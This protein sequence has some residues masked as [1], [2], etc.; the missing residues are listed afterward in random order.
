MTDNNVDIR[1]ELPLPIDITG[2]L[3]NVI[4]L[5]WP[6]AVIKDGK[7]DWR[8]DNRLVLSVPPEDRH[9]NAKKAKKYAEVK[10]HLK[11]ETDAQIAELGPD[12][13]DMGLPEYLAN[14]YIAMARTWMDTYPEATNYLESKLYDKERNHHWVFTVAKGSDRTP[15]SLRKKAEERTAELEAT[16]E[17]LREEIADLR[18][19]TT[20]CEDQEIE[21]NRLKELLA[22][23]DQELNYWSNR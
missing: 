3:I 15:H 5:T 20:K 23:K 2:T 9:K 16:V 13:I 18:P 12:S 14:L 19:L 21:I 10:A 22:E 4:G 7:G 6:N 1:I 11:A 8:C 17:V